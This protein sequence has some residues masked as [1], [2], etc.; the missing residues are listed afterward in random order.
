M[1]TP[2]K[3]F[4]E[5]G[6]TSA[7]TKGVV[8]SL[9]AA[10]N[11]VGG[12]AA[13]SQALREREFASLSSDAVLQGLRR[14]FVD[15]QYLWSGKITPELYDEECSFTDPTLSFSGL[16]TFE[17][18]LENLDPWINRFVPAA[19]RQVELKSLCIA[20][21][22]GDPSLPSSQVVVEAEWRMVGD[23]RL[24][25]KPRLDLDGRTRYTLGGV[26]GRISA[27]DEAWAI[28]PSEALLQLVRPYRGNELQ[29]GMTTAASAAAPATA[30]GSAAASPAATAASAAA[31]SAA[32]GMAI[33]LEQTSRASAEHWAGRRDGRPPPQPTVVLRDAP[34]FVVLP[35][36]GNAGDET[37]TPTQDEH[38]LF[39]RFSCHS[40][41][42]AHQPLARHPTVRSRRLHCASPAA[43]GGGPRPAYVH[44]CACVHVCICACVHVCMC[45][46]VCMC[47]CVHV[48]MYA[49][50]HVCMCACVHVCM[51]ACTRRRRA[52]SSL[53]SIVPEP[54]GSN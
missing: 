28:T 21:R 10:V 8:S 36:F 2:P 33:A 19:N 50:V 24:P 4:S 29:A 49:C 25:W 27:Y 17:A 26:G 13:S 6:G 45:M 23:L 42:L 35:G 1:S 30:A 11:T 3:S 38:L 43:R 5:I 32:D 44:A 16:S 31:T 22:G 51:C 15:N 34:P 52:C 37:C 20:D 53:Y 54:S 40:A 41:P 9:T 48:C 47:A 12:K 7:W 39:F 46:H 14:D 18:N